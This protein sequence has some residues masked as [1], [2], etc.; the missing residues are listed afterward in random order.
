VMLSQRARYLE[1]TWRRHYGSDPSTPRH[2]TL[3]IRSLP[4][5]FMRPWVTHD[6]VDGLR[7]WAELGEV[8]KTPWPQKARASSE[9]LNL[10]RQ[11]ARPAPSYLRGIVTREVALGMFAD[12]VDPRALIAARCAR[13]AVAVERFKRDRNGELPPSLSVLV[14]AYLA[15][16]PADPYSGQSLVFR[17]APGSYTIYSVG[18]NQQD[19]GGDLTSELQAAIAKGSSV[20]RIRGNDIGLRVL[21]LQ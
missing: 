10:Y 19:D 12:A 3:P 7:V 6:I 5:L 8:A 17:S 2:Y 14:P 20:R 15:E 16:L 1:M 18:S 4:D 21:T 11:Q 9:I 13:I